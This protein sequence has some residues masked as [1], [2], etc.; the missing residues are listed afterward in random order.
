MQEAKIK[1]RQ[2]D[3]YLKKEGKIY[4]EKMLNPHILLL[5]P[6]DAGKSTFLKQLRIQNGYN[7]SKEELIQ[8]RN[9][10]WANF[11]SN[12]ENL[13]EYYSNNGGDCNVWPF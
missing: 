11:V 10:I 7:F 5:G 2:I 13:S 3:L 6:S 8:T 9:Q 12:I 1:S 4:A